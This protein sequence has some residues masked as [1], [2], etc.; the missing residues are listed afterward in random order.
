MMFILAM[1]VLVIIHEGFNSQGCLLASSAPKK[2]DDFDQIAWDAHTNP[3]KSS[4]NPWKS[5]KNPGKIHENPGM[6]CVL[7]TQNC[8]LP[9]LF[10]PA[11]WPR[12]EILPQ[13]PQIDATTNGGAV[14][15]RDGNLGK[16]DHLLEDVNWIFWMGYSMGYF[17]WDIGLDIDGI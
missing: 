17:G 12:V 5:R 16:F 15:G 11:P 2:H 6:G 13:E 8:L 7:R 10:P 4:W 14:D 1:V 3:S 9:L